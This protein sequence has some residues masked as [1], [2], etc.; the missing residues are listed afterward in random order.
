MSTSYT[1]TLKETMK[2]TKDK[3]ILKALQYLAEND[4][5]SVSLNSI[6]E[7]TMLISELTKDTDLSEVGKDFVKSTLERIRV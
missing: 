7:G 5:Q 3:I 1:G 6:A 2:E 4:F